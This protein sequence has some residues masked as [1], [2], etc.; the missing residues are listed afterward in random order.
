MHCWPHHTFPA[1]SALRP[2][3]RHQIRVWWER[4]KLPPQD[5][6]FSRLCFFF[7]SLSLSLCALCLSLFF[8]FFL[9]FSISPYDL[10]SPS[11]PILACLHSLSMHVAV[12][13]PDLPPLFVSLPVISRVGSLGAL[14]CGLGDEEPAVMVR[15]I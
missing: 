11:H 1:R 4:E 3:G 8:F 15:F 2:I 10:I 9:V 5:L 14:V 12:L 6:V 13:P 7:L